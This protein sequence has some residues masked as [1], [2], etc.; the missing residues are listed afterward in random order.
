M[1][2]RR[3][4]NANRCDRR[5]AFLLSALL[6]GTPLS[7]WAQSPIADDEG[8]SIVSWSSADQ[9]VGQTA[10]VTGKI[11]DV[12]RAGRVNFLNFDA[13][14]RDVFKVVVFENYVAKFPDSLRDMYLN[15]LV[16]VRGR[17][18]LYKEVPQIEV[19]SPGQ[20]RIVDRLPTTRIVER[21][22]KKINQQIR[23]ATFNVRNL[24]D[25]VD[26]PYYADETTVAKPREELSRIA[27]TIRD[28]DA[29]A[30]GLQ[31]V[32]SRGYLQRFNDVFLSDLG[33]EVVHYSGN[34]Q[35]GSGLALLTRIPVGK[36]TSH[37][38][39]KFRN[40]LGEWTRFSRDLLCIEL[41]PP[42]RKSFEV[43]IT[44]LKSKRGGAAETE[45][46]RQAEAAQIRQIAV[47]R[48]ALDAAARIVLMGD[49]NDTR[50]SRPI[51]S[52]L[53]DNRFVGFFDQVPQDVV[54]YN[55]PP[56]QAMIDFLFLSPQ[57]SRELVDGSYRIY[58]QSLEQSGSDHN[59]VIA[60][61]EFAR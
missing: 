56:Y 17:V 34:D 41:L 35:R 19:S 50:D 29:D 9:V 26:D 32:E 57:A 47:E 23:L 58:E 22:P 31:E 7:L 59:P 55:L 12:G 42:D 14:R 33:Y 25:G 27:K 4:N 53:K 20:I 28:M 3:A 36:V 1:T 48:L 5:L 15:K 46:Q 13:T 2:Q 37:R 24:F 44:H 10:V 43:W 49:F 11:V 54:T 45:P 6:V 39:R 30:V 51:Q 8:L 52:L 21:H 18:T 16:A 40:R 38:H 60:E 61:F